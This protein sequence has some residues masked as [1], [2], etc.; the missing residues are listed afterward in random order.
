MKLNWVGLRV[1]SN[2]LQFGITNLI[3]NPAVGTKFL[4][5]RWEHLP[6]LKQDIY[7]RLTQIIQLM[8]HQT[9]VKPFSLHQYP[10]PIKQ[11]EITFHKKIT[12]I[13]R[14]NRQNIL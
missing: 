13:S 9:Y 1:I 10:N 6:D 4:V 12:H 5:L 7:N 8:Q 3:R 14:I 2:E 11:K